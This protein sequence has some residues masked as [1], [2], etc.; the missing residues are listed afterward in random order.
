MKYDPGKAYPWPVLRP[1]G[2]DKDYPR[3]EFEVEIDM[4]RIE[5]STAVRA[6]ASFALGDPDLLGLVEQESARYVLLVS[7]PATHHRSAHVST[8]PPIAAEF[9]NG[10]LAGR[11]EVRGLLV[12]VR[13]V[14]GFR[15]AGWH[16]DY[17]GRRY[18]IEAGGVL[19]E[20]GPEIYWIDKAEEAAIGSIFHVAAEEGPLSGNGRWRCDLLGDRVLLRMSPDDLRAFGIARNRVNTT[21]EAASV[22]NGVY[23]PALVHVL[24]EA[25][26]DG[27]EYADRRW[28][29]A[30]NERLRDLGL[31]GLGAAAARDRLADAQQLLEEPFGGALALWAGKAP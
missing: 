13:P 27:D 16:D 22:M 19:A 30:L 28:Y 10:A 26:R 24:Q 18:D 11:T 4:D 12:A 25:D 7:A 15:A 8:G 20:D 1:G 6:S 5:G 17:A 9:A 2:P 31:P 3:A 21:P 23:L 29:R 14:P